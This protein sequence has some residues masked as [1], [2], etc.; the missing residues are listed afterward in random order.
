MIPGSG[1]QYWGRL[2]LKQLRAVEVRLLILGGVQVPAIC[3]STE[4]LPLWV[5]R[6]FVRHECHVAQV[7]STSAHPLIPTIMFP[8][9]RGIVQRTS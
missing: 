4:E 7:Y 6:L 9:I 2:F 5:L 3:H 8:A 1:C